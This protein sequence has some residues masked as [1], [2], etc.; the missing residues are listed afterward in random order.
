V[1]KFRKFA[2]IFVPRNGIPNCILFRGMVQTEFREFAS[3]FYDKEFRAFFSSGNCSERNSE[4]FL[5]HGTAGIPLEQTNSSVYSDFHRII[6]CR[7]LP[8]Y[9]N[10][11]NQL[12]DIPTNK[13]ANHNSI[14]KYIFK[15][16]KEKFT[17]YTRKSLT[18]HVEACSF[19]NF[20]RMNGLKQ[21][22]IIH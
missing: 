6:F 5:F 2:S 22:F 18:R 3:M 11:S 15:S 14:R 20:G 17:L 10:H 8:T 7:K 13:S 19:P 12:Q 16:V 1:T 4:S 21:V 9:R